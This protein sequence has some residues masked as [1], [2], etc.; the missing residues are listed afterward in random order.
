MYKFTLNANDLAVNRQ[1]LGAAIVSEGLRPLMSPSLPQ[2]LAT[3]LEACWQLD[4]NQRPTAGQLV[5]MMLEWLSHEKF[6]PQSGHDPPKLSNRQREEARRSSMTA[7][8]ESQA[9]ESGIELLRPL[10][11]AAW[12]R[13]CSAGSRKARRT[14]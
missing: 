1:E 13:D 12:L 6:D 8:S 9:E 10:Q 14:C 5:A 7:R 3:I 4:S 11:A 2:G